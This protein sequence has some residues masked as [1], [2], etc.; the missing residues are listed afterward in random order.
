MLTI[1]DF[2]CVSEF[3]I[4]S[5]P[6]DIYFDS[7]NDDMPV[8]ITDEL[9]EWSSY[10]GDTKTKKQSFM[11]LLGPFKENVDYWYL[12]GEQYVRHYNELFAGKPNSTHPDPTTLTQSGKR[13]HLILSGPCF[14]YALLSMN[15][16]RSPEIRRR[17]LV[18][19]K[20]IKL[21][22]QY[23]TMYA[24]HQY[25]REGRSGLHLTAPL[26]IGVID[27]VNGT[28]SHIDKRRG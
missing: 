23:Q 17:F 12:T 24:C 2:V 3:L 26:N 14:K 28:K 11:K 8:Y 19:E 20:L 21:Y 22:M 10:A 16:S 7:A 6:V 4:D 1:E 15:T 5:S 9:L 27:R 18:R 25:E 13:M